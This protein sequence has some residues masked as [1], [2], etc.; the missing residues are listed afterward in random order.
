MKS[1]FCLTD[2][3]L[4]YVKVSH[5]V[6][7]GKLRMSSTRILVKLLTLFSTAF[8]CRSQLLMVWTEVH[9]LLYKETGK[10]ARP[11]EWC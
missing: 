7:Q 11:K 4:F 9:C 1:R 2:L 3:I 6:D 8:F 5:L 10:I